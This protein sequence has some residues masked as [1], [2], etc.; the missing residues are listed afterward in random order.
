MVP[1]ER[2][3]SFWSL[4]GILD[5]GRARSKHPRGHLRPRRRF[6]AAPSGASPTGTGFCGWAFE[7][8]SDRDRARSKHPR[9]HLRPGP[10][11][12]ETPSGAS[13][14]ETAFCGTTLGGIS[15]RGRPRSNHPRGHRRPPLPSPPALPPAAPHAPAAHLHRR[16][17]NPLTPR[18]GSQ[19]GST[20]RRPPAWSSGR[21]GPRGRCGRNTGRPPRRT[22]APARGSRLR[23]RA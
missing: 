18:T 22:T 8:I 15:D 12:V 4:G 14:T 13:S 23:G 2:G 5:R 19:T 17:P 10:G 7:G 21:A 3:V 6:A 16:H 11:S 20:R 1:T 9:G